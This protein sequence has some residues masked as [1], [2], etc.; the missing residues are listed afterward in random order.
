LGLDVEL[1]NLQHLEQ[2]G[3]SPVRY[4]FKIS[5]QMETNKKQKS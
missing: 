4:D 2:S 1:K 5:L 3:G